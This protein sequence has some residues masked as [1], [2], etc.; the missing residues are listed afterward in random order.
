MN[1]LLNN[2]KFYRIAILIFNTPIRAIFNDLLHFVV[3]E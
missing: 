2:P 1:F 3:T